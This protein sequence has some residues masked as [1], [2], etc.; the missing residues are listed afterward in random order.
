MNFKSISQI[1]AATFVVS[2]LSVPT[3]RLIAGTPKDIPP[4]DNSQEA[5]SVPLATSAE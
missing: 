1:L 5:A 3:C 4:P 2:F